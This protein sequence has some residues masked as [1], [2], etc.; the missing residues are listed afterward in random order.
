MSF[1]FLTQA[2]LPASN[3]RV[4]W[5]VTDKAVSGIAPAR[6][7]TPGTSAT[8]SSPDPRARSLRPS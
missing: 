5:W 7:P 8:G 3:F 6:L 4:S 1:Q 2:E